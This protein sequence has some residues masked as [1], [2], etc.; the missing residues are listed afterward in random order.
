MG[1]EEI[2]ARNYVKAKPTDDELRRQYAGQ[3]SVSNA[4]VPT[5]AVNGVSQEEQFWSQQ[6]RQLPRGISPNGIPPSTTSP[7]NPQQPQ[8]QTPSQDNDLRRQLLQAQDT[9]SDNGAGTSVDPFS[10]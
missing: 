9:G 10:G 7:Q 6:S 1:S 2:E 8:Q 5:A 4:N 3:N